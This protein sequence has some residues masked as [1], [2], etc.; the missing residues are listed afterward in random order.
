MTDS[1]TAF[2][3][4]LVASGAVT[5]LVPA[6]RIFQPWYPATA[7]FPLITFT[8]VNNYNDDSDYFDDQPRSDHME[9]ETHVFTPPPTTGNANSTH[10]IYASMDTALKAD[11]WTR[12]FS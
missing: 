3:S 10:P 4:V 8:E 7:T 5:A 12:E 11:G 6:T 2:R 9:I 1:Q